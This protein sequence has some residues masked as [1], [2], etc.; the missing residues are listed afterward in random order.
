MADASLA[1]IISGTDPLAPLELRATQAQQLLNS[2][3][4]SSQWANQ[5]PFG[6]LARTIAGFQAP[7][8][9]QDTLSQIVQARQ[10]ANPDIVKMLAAPQGAASY[11]AANPN[12]SPLAMALAANQTPN[13]AIQGAGV[14]I[15]NQ[16]NALNLNAYQ[17]R[18]RALQQGTPMPGAITA[19]VAKSAATSPTLPASAPNNPVST[20]TSASAAPTT[21]AP[22]AI[23]QEIIEGAQKL[24]DPATVAKLFPQPADRARFFA[25]LPGQLR[26]AYM[27]LYPLGGGSGARP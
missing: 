13:E 18:A 24:P 9:A 11:A 1:S 25:G 12:I 16:I 5:G 26:Q 15:A 7:S 3:R 27:Q 23:P 6:A 21:V 19:P 22:A 14:G 17:A 8:M 20:S 2:V 4:D 10:A